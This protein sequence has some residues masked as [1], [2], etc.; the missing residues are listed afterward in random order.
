MDRNQHY[1]EK[2][3]DEM[4]GR[5]VSDEPDPERALAVKLKLDELTSKVH[6]LQ[7]TAEKKRIVD[8][9]ARIR[10]TVAAEPVNADGDLRQEKVLQIIDAVIDEETCPRC[11]QETCDAVCIEA[12]SNATRHYNGPVPRKYA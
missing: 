10:E 12:E 8:A 7:E 2:Q 3:L 1:S 5:S 6:K 9:I 4:L 11:K